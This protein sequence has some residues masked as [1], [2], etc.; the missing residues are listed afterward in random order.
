MNRIIV[1]ISVCILL[2]ACNSNDT[3]H[4]GV[5]DSTKITVDTPKAVIVDSSKMPVTGV[6]S[7][8][9]DSAH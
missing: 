9:K 7:T 8:K 4:A 3:S 6:D 5:Q 1:I 2:T